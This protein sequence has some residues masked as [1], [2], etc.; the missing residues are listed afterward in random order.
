VSESKLPSVL[1]LRVPSSTHGLVAMA[2]KEVDGDNVED[3]VEMKTSLV[4]GNGMVDDYVNTK[5][6]EV[7]NTANENDGTTKE[8]EV[9]ENVV[10]VKCNTNGEK[11]ANEG[12]NNDEKRSDTKI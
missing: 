7:R 4:R 10:I 5:V 8:E 6:E 11:D 12:E 9:K 3:T 1:H 2:R